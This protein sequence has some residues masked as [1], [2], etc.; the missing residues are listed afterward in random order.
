MKSAVLSPP[1]MPALPAARGQAQTMPRPKAQAE[2]TCD[3]SAWAQ[4]QPMCWRSEAFAEDLFDD[5]QAGAG[6]N[7]QRVTLLRRALAT[8]LRR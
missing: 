6:S 1:L 8:V 4:T 7:R 3:S 5:A 2:A